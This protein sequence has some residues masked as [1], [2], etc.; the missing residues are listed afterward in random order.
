MKY[1]TVLQEQLGTDGLHHIH[2]HHQENGVSLVSENKHSHSPL[3]KSEPCKSQD[4]QD[5]M[6]VSPSHHEPWTHVDDHDEALR[7]ALLAA[8]AEDQ[9]EREGRHGD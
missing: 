9:L 7:S 6:N 4:I 2:S 5:A 8:S 3:I 1:H